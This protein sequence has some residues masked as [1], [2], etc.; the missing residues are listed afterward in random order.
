MGVVNQPRRI[1]ITG[2]TGNIGA[3]TLALLK[4]RSVER[5]AAISGATRQLDVT[6]GTEC[7]VCNYNDER[8]VAE[9]LQEVDGALLLVPFDEDMVTWGT[10][11]VEAARRAGVGFILRI[12]GLAAAPD[13]PSK[14]GQLHGQIDEAVKASGV[15]YCILRCNS[16]MQNFSGVYRYMIRK[17]G[18]LSLPE[19]DARASLVD[20]ADIGEVA[21]VILA[22]PSPHF[23]R[24]YDLDGPNALSNSDAVNIIS[25][26]TGR[27][28]EYRPISAEEAC[29][30]YEKLGVSGWRIDVLDSLSRFIRD[31]HADRSGQTLQ[32]L[33]R[34]PPRTFERFSRDT[35]E[36]WLDG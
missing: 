1:L 30:T 34:R 12:S 19:G 14:M 13:C 15:P 4:G 11:F 10:R 6:A 35:H 26:V 31:G 23:G 29:R 3:A 18:V 27:C 16:F 7:R 24:T 25:S 32:K 21:A 20:T 28:I 2:A 17:K 33:L 8:Q 22:D 5:V 36:C 9:A